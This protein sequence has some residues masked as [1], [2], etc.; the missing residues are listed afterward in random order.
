[1]KHCFKR[2]R[3][4][5]RALL[6]Q[7][8]WVVLGWLILQGG[9]VFGSERP[10]PA[11][12][13]TFPRLLG[14][15]ISIKNYEDLQYQAELAK[16]DIVII[17]FH[18]YWKSAI[19]F[20]KQ[21]M[22]DVVRRIKSLNPANLIGNYTILNEAYD[23]LDRNLAEKDKYYK[24]YNEG[25][26]LTDAS[27]QKVQWTSNYNSWEVNFTS[28]SVPDNEG[29]RYPEWLAERD[30]RIYFS[31][32]PE[33]DIWMF[34]NVFPC[35][36]VKRADWDL[37][38]KDERGDDPRIAQAFRQGQAEEWSAA[39][40]LAPNLIQLGNVD[41]DLAFPEYKGKLGAAFMEGAMGYKWSLESKLG[42]SAMMQRYRDLLANTA[43]PHLVALN[44][45][46]APNDYRLFRFGFTSCLMDNG[47]YSYSPQDQTYSSVLWFDEYDVDLGH[48]VDLP[49]KAAWQNG[50]YR[51]LFEKGMVLVNPA[52]AK[53][54]VIIEPGYRAITGK[55]D[56]EINHGRLVTS[57]TIAGK[58]GVVLLKKN[59][60]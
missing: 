12:K 15:N 55:Q 18:P 14:M 1:M 44:V 22:R 37:D 29:K 8:L 13:E 47:Y 11:L 50:V 38:G 25:W 40:R 9:I 19:G 36:R 24:L 28:W 5:S 43:E 3:Y 27:G 39:K 31:K 2:C 32:I 53:V 42:W 21:S 45:A 54:T 58:D 4:A 16:L 7:C 48:A 41:N 26:W 46:G 60:D 17:N 20:K 10:L 33:F 23:N 49:Q 56:R 51:R 34:D 30:F 52:K 59:N 6:L 35:S 57:L